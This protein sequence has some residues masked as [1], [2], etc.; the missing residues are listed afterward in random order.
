MD[1]QLTGRLAAVAGVVLEGPAHRDLFEGFEL[2]LR[3]LDRGR[4]AQIWT[5]LAI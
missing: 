1:A 5:L 3:A 2:A 4:F